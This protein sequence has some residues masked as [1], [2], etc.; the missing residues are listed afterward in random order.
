MKTVLAISVGSLIVIAGCTRWNILKGPEQNKS[1][2]PG[3][4]PPVAA[5]VGY[6]D[7]NSSRIDTVRS[8]DLDMTCSVGS[9]SFGVRGKM[10][11]KKN[12]NFLLAADVFGAREVDLG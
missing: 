2:P 4:A 11:A 5:L 9:Q 10:I 1:E 7:N 8:T 6:L 3:K 12:K